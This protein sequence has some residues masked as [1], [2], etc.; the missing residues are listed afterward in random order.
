MT[1]AGLR[2]VSAEW[3]LRDLGRTPY[4][5]TWAL[6]QRLIEGRRRGEVGDSL[7][8]CEHE[9]VIT[10]GRAGDPDSLGRQRF[11]VISVER[12]GQAT[13]HG[14]G[15]VVVYPIVSMAPA[16]RD[17][18]R[19]MAALEQACIDAMA[20]FGLKCG[21]RDGATGV[22]VGGGERKLVS[23]GVAARRWVSWHGLALNHSPDLAHFGAFRPCGFEATVMTSM[24]RE[25]GGDCPERQAV[26][27]VL[28]PALQ[29]ELEPFREAL[30]AAP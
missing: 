10:V 13:Y 30:G 4:G 16:A 12:G 11:P 3:S 19:W 6:Q 28:M 27:D 9:P 15:Q 14:P 8:V 5:D 21:R 29:R 24:E 1:A 2:S 18:H 7:L 20:A 26:I 23:I 22:W 25:L 17:M